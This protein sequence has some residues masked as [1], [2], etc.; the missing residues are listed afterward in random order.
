[1]SKNENF[2]LAM[3]EIKSKLGLSQEE[4]MT[5]INKEVKQTLSQEELIELIN[6]NKW[7]QAVPS[8]LICKTDE[9]KVERAENILNLIVDDKNLIKKRFLDFGCGEGSVVIAAKNRGA[10]LSIGYDPSLND[11]TNDSLTN[12]LD[13]IKQHGLFDTILIYDVLDH[14]DDPV[15]ILKTAFNLLS[16]EGVILLRTHP[17]TSR[18]GAHAYNTINKA[19]IHLFLNEDTLKSL[20]VT[21][22]NKQKIIRP[23][24]TYEKWIKAADLKIKHISEDRTKVDDIFV[25]NPLKGILMNK[26]SLTEWTTFQLELSF[27]DYILTK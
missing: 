4:L 15:S 26:L 22:D 16:T 3:E 17:W 6:S 20:G 8:V 25:T 2:K 27:I 24:G 19:Y 9:D 5:L 10:E 23:L 7:P 21:L 11:S 13:A 12:N 18:H 14:S 1:M